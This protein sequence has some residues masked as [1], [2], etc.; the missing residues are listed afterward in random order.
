MAPFILVTCGMYM[1]SDLLVA[2]SVSD[3][4]FRQVASQP[5]PVRM[6]EG[7]LGQ[8]L[9]RFAHDQVTQGPAA[10]KQPL[11]CEWFAAVAAVL[12]GSMKCAC[13]AATSFVAPCCVM[14]CAQVCLSLLGTWQGPSWQP[15]VSTLL[16]VGAATQGA[17]WLPGSTAA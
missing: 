5:Q 4:W 12:H 6:W 9:Q 14:L 7:K 15:G 16:Q 10:C 3:D 2:G 1:L 8:L 17:M 13:S 11:Q